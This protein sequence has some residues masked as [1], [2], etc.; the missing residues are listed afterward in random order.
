VT[1][2]PSYRC[3]ACGL[4]HAR[5]DYSGQTAPVVALACPFCHH[6]EAERVVMGSDLASLEQRLQAL[7]EAPPRGFQKAGQR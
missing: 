2:P 6:G 5:M 4:F 7:E 3:T 1:L